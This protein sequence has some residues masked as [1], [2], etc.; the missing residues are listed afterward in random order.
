MVSIPFMLWYKKCGKGALGDKI[1]FVFVILMGILPCIGNMIFDIGG[2]SPT[3][4]LTYF[5]LGY[6][7][8]A[9]EKV[10][11][12]LDKYRFLLLLI[13]AAGAILTTIFDHVFYEAV[14]WLAVLTVLGMGRHYLNFSGKITGYLSKSSFG[15]YIFHQSWIVAVA[16]FVFRL[17][18]NYWIQIPVILLLSIALT[19]LTYEIAKRIP[20]LRWMFGLK[21]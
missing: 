14:S 12:K 15:I 8:L 2:K 17:T 21:K 3:E 18:D 9:S 7:F 1:P 5:L 11:Q 20:V 13:L 10:P 19:Y 16:F 6:F 4:Y